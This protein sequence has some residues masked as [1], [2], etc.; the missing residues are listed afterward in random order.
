MMNA[1]VLVADDEAP[2]RQLVRLY[3]MKEGFAVVEASTGTE[4][5]SSIRRGDVDVGIV[6][7]MLPEMDGFEVVRRI[8]Q[9]ST[10]PIILLTARGEETS[11][12][13]GLEVGADDYV[14]KPFSPPEVVARVRAQLRRAH[15][16]EES[17]SILHAGGIRLDRIARECHVDGQVVP[18]TRREFDLLGTFLEHPGRVYRRDQLLEMVWGSPYVSPK[19]V[20]VHIAAL[21]RKLGD[22]ISITAFRGVGYRFDS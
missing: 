12:V 11:R 21:R 18:L 6:D 14:V 7:V 19:T 1:R 8:R 5:V 15:G 3:L 17:R 13:A 4:A 10:I 9:N 20:D 22:T 16:F 2:L